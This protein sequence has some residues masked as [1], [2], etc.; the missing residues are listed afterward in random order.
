MARLLLPLLAV[1]LTLG[2]PAA[3]RHVLANQSPG[4]D[5]LSADEA[6]LLDRINTYRQVNGLSPLT[7]SPTL[8]AAARHHAESMAEHNYFPADYSVQ[9]EGPDHDQTITWQQNIANAGY[10]DN[11]H[12][13]R[14]EIIGA[15]TDSVTKIQR[16]LRGIAAY[17]K[18]LTDRRFQAVGIGFSTNPESDEGTYWALTFGSLRDGEIAP[19]PGVTV[20]VTIEAAGR[21]KNSTSSA[22]AYDGDFTTAWATTAKR[23]PRSAYVWF[24]LG[25]VQNIGAIEWMFSQPGAADKFKIEISLDRESWTVVAAKSNGVV[26]A[27]RSAQWH[28]RARYLRF[29]FTNPNRDPVIGYLA[30]VRVF[31]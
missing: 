12:T 30:E 6:V 20:P 18:V 24:D 11:T 13:T 29:S 31:R 8:T 23:P 16:S 2:A 19:C 17:D 25:S 14:S 1:L 5:C 9:F 27:W 7:A 21:S 28:G 22:L 4:S 10:P 26:N 15:G 3:D